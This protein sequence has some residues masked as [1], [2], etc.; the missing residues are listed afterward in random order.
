MARKLIY[1]KSE[2]TDMYNAIKKHLGISVLRQRYYSLYNE[3][4]SKQRTSLTELMY[5]RLV[6]LYEIT[7]VSVKKEVPFDLSVKT[8]WLQ[9]LTI[10]KES[11]EFVEL[12]SQKKERINL[13]IYQLKQMLPCN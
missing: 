5:N 7:I 9:T 6:E 8:D 10:Y 1:P 13:E 12:P 3:Y 4:T 2:C 11:N